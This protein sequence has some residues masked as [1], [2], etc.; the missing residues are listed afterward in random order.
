MSAFFEFTLQW[1]ESENKR[2]KYIDDTLLLEENK[3]PK[4][5]L[6]SMKLKKIP[7]ILKCAT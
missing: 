1:K 6:G 7:Q 2:N 3:S 5:H 4:Q